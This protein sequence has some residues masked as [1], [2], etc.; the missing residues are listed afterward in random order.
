[1]HKLLHKIFFNK[2]IIDPDG[3]LRFFW[4]IIVVIIILINMFYAPF[5]MAFI[6]FNE[7]E[8]DYHFGDDSI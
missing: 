7:I 5:E 1:V 3:N 4:D 8:K 6:D 2:F